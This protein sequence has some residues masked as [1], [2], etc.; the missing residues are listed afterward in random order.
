ML[1]GKLETARAIF[2]K[3]GIRGLLRISIKIY[4]RP[5]IMALYINTKWLPRSLYSRINCMSHPRKTKR[6]LDTI[7]RDLDL[8]VSKHGDGIYVAEDFVP[9]PG[10]G[11]DHSIQ[12]VRREISE[13][14]RILLL[15]GLDNTILEI[16]VGVHGGTHI[17]WRHI[18]KRVVTI[19]RSIG[20]VLNLRVNEWLDN[21]S[22]VIVGSSQDHSTLERVQACLDSVD[23]LF[24]DGDHSYEGVAKDWAMYHGLVRPGG[25]V[26]FHDSICTFP[27]YGIAKFLGDLSQG[28]IDN[29]C[30]ILH[31]I[32]FS[33]QVGISY[34]EC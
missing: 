21:R 25:I 34:E 13:F 19:E 14:V 12:Q 10:H 32:V 15:K 2:R 23:V 27:P 22:T 18:F 4:L 17:L 5:I 3:E 28:L 6:D 16:G 33:G 24:L 29:K 31:H 11:L 30:H 26:V 1:K 7:M 20:T 9:V 8:W